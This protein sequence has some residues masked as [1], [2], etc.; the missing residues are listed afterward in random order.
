MGFGM[1]LQIFADRGGPVPDAVV[2]N[3]GEE[4][5]PA[6]KTVPRQQ[7]AGIRH[8]WGTAQT[9]RAGAEGPALEFLGIT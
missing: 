2:V 4:K 6:P 8:W 1:R 5:A 7:S 9:L 3:E